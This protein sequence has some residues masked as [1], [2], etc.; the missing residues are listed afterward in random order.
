MNKE[1]TPGIFIFVGENRSRTAQEK[2]WSWQE[3]QRTGKPVLCAKP[4]WEALSQININ[5]NH[6]IFFNLWDDEWNLN[7]FIPEILREM[8]EDG[9]AIVAM[10]RKVHI[11][12]EKLDIPHKEM[13]HPAARGKIRKTSLYRE[14]VKETLL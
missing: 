8:S 14:H 1:Q 4:L 5:P 6:Q 2:G 12:L 11:Q 3:C 13:V 10:G 9:E 7:N